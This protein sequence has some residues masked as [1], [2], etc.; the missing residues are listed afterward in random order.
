MSQWTDFRF[1]ETCVKQ[2]YCHTTSCVGWSGVSWTNWIWKTSH[3]FDGGSKSVTPMTPYIRGRIEHLWAAVQLHVK[4]NKLYYSCSVCLLSFG[5]E[6]QRS[7]GGSCKRLCR[8][9]GKMHGRVPGE[10]SWYRTLEKSVSVCNGRCVPA[11]PCHESAVWLRVTEESEVGLHHGTAPSLASFLL[12]KWRGLQNGLQPTRE[13][14]R[15]ENFIWDALVR[16]VVTL[17]RDRANSDNNID[18]KEQNGKSSE[19]NRRDLLK[20]SMKK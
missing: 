13:V 8:A 4:K 19:N 15:L 5:R 9:I 7:S 14:S 20:A 12:W 11:R 10:E 6:T 18:G 3:V 2:I 1:L 16:D 17:T